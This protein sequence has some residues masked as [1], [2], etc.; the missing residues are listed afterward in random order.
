MGACVVCPRSPKSPPA[1]YGS[2]TR[3]AASAAP[4]SRRHSTNC[5]RPLQPT[6][7]GSRAHSDRL[8]APRSLRA[9]VPGQHVAACI[10]SDG[11]RAFAWRA[12]GRELFY[13]DP[14]GAFMA[15]SLSPGASGSARAAVPTRLFQIRRPALSIVRH[16][17]RRATVSRQH[18]ESRRRLPTDEVVV[19][20]TRR[21]R[22]VAQG[23]MGTRTH[24]LIRASTCMAPGLHL[25]WRS[26]APLPTSRRN[27]S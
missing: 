10:S 8:R 12:D 24:V 21:L 25:C 16:H 15:V 3:R 22:R 20:W 18:R 11:A 17:R 14:S 26:E 23:P 2:L 27:W 13:V 6:A 1:T 19:D 7:P 5:S 4:F 9:R